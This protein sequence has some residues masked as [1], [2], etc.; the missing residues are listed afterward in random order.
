MARKAKAA[1]LATGGEDTG[2]Q[3]TR[4]HVIAELSVN[5]VERLVL[6]CGYVA[7]RPVPDYGYDLRIETFDEQG[8]PEDGHVSLQLKATDTAS[9]Y[10]LATEE[11]F[12]FPVSSKD[13][14]FWTKALMP[15]LFILY[16]AAIEEAYWLDIQD[17][18]MTRRPRVEGDALRVHIPR[19]HVL[20]VQTIRVMRQ[21]KQDFVQSIK[22]NR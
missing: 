17:Y 15:V 13:Y 20:G 6:K 12:S 18:E 21:R 22:Q 2:K 8:R 5:F 3:R 10:E 14:R 11:S 7:Q 16:D 19:S 1:A 9:R 4:E